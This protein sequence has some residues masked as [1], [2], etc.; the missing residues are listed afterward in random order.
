[1]LPLVL[2]VEAGTP[3][4]KLAEDC[5]LGLLL[6]FF[7]NSPHRRLPGG[8]GAHLKGGLFLRG[9]GDGEAQG[10]RPPAFQ[11]LHAHLCVYRL[12]LDAHGRL[13]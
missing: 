12:H 13:R 1:M 4:E 10:L 3:P 2:G 9:P 6:R 5:G 8:L 7:E 11:Q